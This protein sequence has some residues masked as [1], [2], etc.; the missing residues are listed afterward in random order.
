VKLTADLY[1]TGELAPSGFTFTAS[2]FTQQKTA[3]GLEVFVDS[4]FS[5]PPVDG[6]DGEN[7]FGDL[8]GYLI[9]DTTDN[10]AQFRNDLTGLT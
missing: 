8:M 3:Q 7:T 1:D 6:Q 4:N 10:T 2:G 5:F 9:I